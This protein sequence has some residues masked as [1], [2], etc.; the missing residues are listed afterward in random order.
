MIVQGSAWKLGDDIDTDQLMPGRFL[1]LTNPAELGKH[2]LEDLLPNFHSS[3][4][5]GD[6]LVAGEN[7]G[8]GSSREHAVLAL[9]ALGISCLIAKSFA[10]IFFRNAINL[11]IPALVCSTAVTSLEEG[12]IIR[13]HLDTGWIENLTRPFEASAPPLPQFLTAIIDSGGMT[14]YVRQRIRQQSQRYH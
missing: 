3:V 9:K 8:C 10:R 4:Q 5:H 1:N 13:V 2:C 6:I 7:F 11:G 12:D 14:D